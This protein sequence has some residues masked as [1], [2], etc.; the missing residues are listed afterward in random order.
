MTRALD[1]SALVADHSR[2]DAC[3]LRSAWALAKALSPRPLVRVAHATADGEVLNAYPRSHPLDGDVPG[4]PWAVYLTDARGRFRLLCLDL[5]SHSCSDSAIA[6]TALL[7]GLLRELRVS[8]VVCASGPAGGRHVWLALVEGVDAALVAALAHLL[9]AWLPSL[10][11]APLLNPATGCVRPP[12]SPH[13]DGGA[14]RV[15]EGVLA[16]LRTPTVTRSQIEAIVARLAELAVV[17]NPDHSA[18]SAARSR[19]EV[20]RPIAY[21]DGLPYLVGE[22]RPLS[23]SAQDELDDPTSG[24][25]S[26]TMWRVLCAAAAAH[27]RFADVEAIADRPGLEHVRTLRSEQGRSPRPTRGSASTQAVLRRQWIRAV[28]SVARMPALTN[29]A[30]PSMRGP[31]SSPRSYAECWAARTRRV[32]GGQAGPAWRSGACSTRCACSI[33]PTSWLC[34]C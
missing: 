21:A 23:A 3:E 14:S 29:R 19:P 6:Q 11:L 1:R 26:A 31:T 16:T 5:D 10:D 18:T 25:L 7:T 34:R 8:H 32:P 20:A 17:T 12:G 28:N 30:D 24:D 22:R 2:A 33:I 4:T 13:R 9:K 27:W 15:I